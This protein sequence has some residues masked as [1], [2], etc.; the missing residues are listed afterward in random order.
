MQSKPLPI[1]N[2]PLSKFMR[3]PKIY[4]TLPSGGEYWAPGSLELTENGEFP[5]YS[6]TARDELLFKTPDAL[7]I[8]QAVVDVIQSC[9]P[10]ILDA[11]HTPNID[12]DVILIGIRLATYGEKMDTNFSVGEEEMTY[13]V[14]LAMLLNQLYESISWNEKIDIG[15]SMCLYV[16]PVTYLTAS[17]TSLNTF[18][19]QKIMNLVNNSELSEEQ[20]IETFKESFKKLTDLTVGIVNGS[21][22]RIESVAGTTEDPDHIAE[23][24]ANCDKEIFDAVKNRL[25]ELRKQN[26]LKPFKIKATE[27]MIANGSAEE[28]EIPL[29]FDPANF[30]G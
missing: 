25:D 22:Y 18:E 3:Q 27:E 28:I 29:T 26:S 12:I 24:M 15:T 23:F 1:K 11:W 14:D 8:G 7:M 9:I 10:N 5:V 30:F 19:T 6:M 17:K 21:V 13:Q 16:K 20:K 2:N 4:I